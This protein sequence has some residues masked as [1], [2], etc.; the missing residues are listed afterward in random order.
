M[1][2]IRVLPDRLINQIAAG[3]IV[4]RPASVVK[5]LV[6]NSLDAGAKRI[7]AEIDGGGK[8]RITVR[9]DGEGMSRDDALLA[10]EHHATSKLRDAGDLER[11]ATLGF[12]GEA[13]P[14]IAAV[15][16]L[17]LRTIAAAAASQAGTQVEIHGGAVRAVKDIPWARGTEIAVADLFFN[18]PARR[19]FLK[20]DATE[21]SHAGRLFTH[22]ALAWPDR[23]FSLVSNG[24]P[25]IDA[26]PVQDLPGRIHQLFGEEFMAGLVPFDAS[27]PGLRFRGFVA[28]PHQRR[29]STEAQYFFVNGRM[30][31][32]RLLSGA[33]YYAYRN[34]IP[35]GTYPAAILFL[36]L[37]CEEIDVNVHP[38]KTEIRFRHVFPVQAFLRR[39]LESAFHESR[40]F[41][42]LL[43]ETGPDRAESAPE[44]PYPP[45]IPLPGSG[46]SYVQSVRDRL[47]EFGDRRPPASAG[48]LFAPP[49]PSADD[50][51][52]AMGL[53]GEE[54][55]GLPIP[56]LPGPVA[57]ASASGWRV[58]G[59]WRESFIV[60][61]GREELVIIDQHV[62]HE[63]VLFEAYLRQLEDG[64][65]PRQRLLLPIPIELPPA[66]RLRLEELP[67]HFA[68]A[69]FEIEPFG[70]GSLL[71]KAVPALAAACEIELLILDIL[72][73]VGD[74]PP[75]FTLAD[76]RHR[77]A[78]AL[79]CRAAVK[80]NTPL[81]LPAMERL[82]DTLLAAEDPTTCP[83]GRP[84]VL[85]LNV[86]D[87]EKGF[88]RT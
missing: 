16:R 18:L 42:R 55:I 59:Q 63:R 71:V 19:K 14:S 64:A 87:L 17:T 39:T 88:K 81:A 24:R 45:A 1:G 67:A 65:V 25:S 75:V 4:E 78:A 83:H 74:Q 40:A 56:A 85:R 29:A 47:E 3:E 27:E 21:A 68:A 60:A 10:F 82:V 77:A 33:L 8:A 41:A 31:R 80:I 44:S 28:K 22:Y 57:P 73:R 72:D 13:L 38:A 70:S 76:V 32:D 15:S 84:V 9:D 6:E 50:P 11:I 23:H 2:K 7:E 66:Q 34:L 46:E 58:L 86:R 79:S 48:R 62:A 51:L 5:E 36:E 69:G 20:T 49:A 43:D 12:R 26:P 54:G 37:P 30:V 53:A 52:A 35:G 61:A